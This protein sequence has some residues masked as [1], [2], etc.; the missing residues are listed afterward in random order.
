MRAADVPEVISWAGERDHLAYSMLI[1]EWHWWPADREAMIV[2]RP[3]SDDHKDLCRIAAVVHAL[4]DQ[5]KVPVPDWVY[6]YRSSEPLAM[7]P[8]LPRTG[9]IWDRAVA[10]ACNAC[11]YHNVWFSWRD[12]EPLSVA[13]K[14]LKKARRRR[15]RMNT[16]RRFRLWRR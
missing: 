4:C 2:D 13:A 15:R 1:K 10:E 16:V 7:L 5:D 8:T 9:G 3:V 12:I 6:D 11:E 14:R